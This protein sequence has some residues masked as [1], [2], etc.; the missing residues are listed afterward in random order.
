ML[1]ICYQY[2]TF[3]KIDINGLNVLLSD[4][5]YTQVVYFNN[6]C[7]ANLLLVQLYIPLPK[8]IHISSYDRC[9]WA[10]ANRPGNQ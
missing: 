6:L 1:V 3:V 10:G 7:I 4:L 9:S 5:S 8:Y 2:E